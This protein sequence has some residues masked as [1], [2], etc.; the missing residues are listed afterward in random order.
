MEY[1]ITFGGKIDLFAKYNIKSKH[2]E[3]FNHT[4][5]AVSFVRFL[6]FYFVQVLIFKRIIYNKVS[7]INYEQSTLFVL[8]F[9]LFIPLVIQ[10]IFFFYFMKRIVVWLGLTNESLFKVQQQDSLPQSKIDD[11][12][13][14]VAKINKFEDIQLPA[15]INKGLE[16]F[17]GTLHDN[18]HISKKD[19]ANIIDKLGATEVAPHNDNKDYSDVFLE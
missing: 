2:K 16:T 5:G 10:G 7:A 15:E 3:M 18:I 8:V 9:L 1:R 11:S 14:Q 13:I 6:L 19:A 4:S 17:F 12:L